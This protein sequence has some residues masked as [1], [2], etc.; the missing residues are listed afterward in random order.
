M[1]IAIEQPAQKNNQPKEIALEQ[2]V[3][4][5]KSKLDLHL[6]NFSRNAHMYS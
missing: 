6:K 1:L 4:S 2:S 5:F 3:N